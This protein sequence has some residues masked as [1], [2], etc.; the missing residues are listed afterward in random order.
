META[1][2]VTNLLEN[3]GAE[4]WLPMWPAPQLAGM[5]MA[6]PAL[7]VEIGDRFAPGPADR[8]VAHALAFHILDQR[9]GML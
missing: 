7:L 3:W 9:A 8:A 4:E 5:V 2:I 6:R 1:E